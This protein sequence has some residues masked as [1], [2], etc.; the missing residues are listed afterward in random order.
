MLLLWWGG[1]VFP[2]TIGALAF[3]IALIAGMV[4]RQHAHVLES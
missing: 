1:L 2:S 3:N 4:W